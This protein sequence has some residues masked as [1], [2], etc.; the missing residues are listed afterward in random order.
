MMN[1]MALPKY[2]SHALTYH[3]HGLVLADP[4][5]RM[6]VAIVTGQHGD[7]F[8]GLEAGSKMIDYVVATHRGAHLTL[9]D[10]R[11]GRRRLAPLPL[12]GVTVLAAPLY[13]IAG[14]LWGQRRAGEEPAV[15]REVDRLYRPMGADLNRTWPRGEIVAPVW[16]AIQSL[17][18]PV[19]VLDVHSTYK[20]R[21]GRDGVPDSHL[22]VTGRSRAWLEPLVP[23]WLIIDQ[24]AEIGADGGPLEDV[25]NAA[26]HLGVTI[27]ISEDDGAP[28]LLACDLL[29]RILSAG[30][31]A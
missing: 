10:G 24:P 19:I 21:V 25:A 14:H 26:G 17:P 4:A 22:Y 29:H 27:E 7:E 28:G 2:T 9:R 8:A 3:P 13:T 31:P 15:G 1:P 30:P 23:D 16:D 11:G 12:Q 18:G 20:D 5:P 6:S